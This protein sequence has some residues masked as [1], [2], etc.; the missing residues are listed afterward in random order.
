MLPRRS[1]PP[2]NGLQENSALLNSV[3][4]FAALGDEIRL[5]LIVV[6]SGGEALSIKQLTSGTGITRQA[7]TKH[8]HVLADAGL[9][10]D[11]KVGRERLWKFE[12]MQLEE[13]RHSLDL[14]ARQWDYA[15]SK[16]KLAV[17]REP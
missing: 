4:I 12:S 13:A 17:E 10:R 3:P 6:L 2:H 16:L 7:V 11:I 14:I 8:L 15:L 1:T 9:V 5:R